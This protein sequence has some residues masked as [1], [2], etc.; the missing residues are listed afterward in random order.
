M[1]AFLPYWKPLQ[2]DFTG[3]YC[4]K[5]SSLWLV[6][7]QTNRKPHYSAVSCHSYQIR[8]DNIQ[9]EAQIKR[10]WDTGTFTYWPCLADFSGERGKMSLDVIILCLLYSYNHYIY[11]RLPYRLGICQYGGEGAGLSGLI[12]KI[13]RYILNL[14]IAYLLLGYWEF[15]APRATMDL[16]CK[17]H[18][19]FKVPLADDQ[20]HYYLNL[21]GVHSLNISVRMCCTICSR[22]NNSGRVIAHKLC[23]SGHGHMRYCYG[24]NIY[25]LESTTSPADDHSILE[26]SSSQQTSLHDAILWS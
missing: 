16:V 4:N 15:T 17:L 12:V 6:R 14:F 9:S 5:T 20:A 3:L 10:L 13:W 8:I 26:P 7:C 11:C 2:N 22:A 23:R 18:K 25:Y 19:I 24:S 1:T 21:P